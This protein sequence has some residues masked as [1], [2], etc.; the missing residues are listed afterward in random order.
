MCVLV[1]FRRN[2]RGFFN[3]EVRAII[4]QFKGV[5]SLIF[6]EQNTVDLVDCDFV[7]SFDGGRGDD[8]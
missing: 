1:G 6:N 8:G 5:E 4:F 7:M 3:G 2:K